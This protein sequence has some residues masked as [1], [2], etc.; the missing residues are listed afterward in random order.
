MERF[1][2]Q[3]L[4]PS[5]QMV[6][7]IASAC[8]NSVSQIEQNFT[9]LN[10]RI[11]DQLGYKSDP[12]LVSL[13]GTVTVDGIAGLVRLNDQIELEVAPK[14][15]DPTS[16]SWRSDFFLIAVL[17]RTGHLLPHDAV[18]SSAIGPSDL[19]TLIALT[20][21]SE[22]EQNRRTPIR[23][24]KRSV[25]SDF[26]LDGD[27]D[28]ESTVLPGPDGFRITRL[29][30]SRKNPINATL[31][32]AIEVLISEV[33]DLDIETRLRDA[34]RLFQN[35]DEPPAIFPPLGPR[36]SRW[37]LAYELSKMVISENRL[38]PEKG[39]FRG[40]GFILSTWA[41]WESLC[42]EILSRALSDHRVVRQRPLTLGQRGDTPVVVRPD[43]TPLRGDHLPFLADAKYKTRIDKSP[44]ISPA[45]LYESM[46]FLTA[47]RTNQMLLLYPAKQEP[48]RLPTGRWALFDHVQIGRLHFKAFEVQIQGLSKP[49]GFKKISQAARIAIAEV[50]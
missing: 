44:R 9:A 33:V 46:A 17:V 10:R 40:T 23:G 35:Q 48:D 37:S 20:L 31:T 49:G 4:V 26:S 21:L 25:T 45:D 16:A 8:G 11:K 12:I 39:P 41:A 34:L 15:L 28:W 19:A 38:G 1:T 30:L 5:R 42:E 18:S 13:D 22:I 3:E 32:K 27:V 29:N 6:Q 50:V 47:G 36:H 24:Y 43:I 14:F 2:I 7:Q